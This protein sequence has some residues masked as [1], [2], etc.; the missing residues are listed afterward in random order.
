MGS[1]AQS[2]LASKARYLGGLPLCAPCPPAVSGQV[3]AAGRGGQG[4][5]HPTSLV[6]APMVRGHH[7]AP[8]AHCA[9]SWHICVL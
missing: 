9:C 2:L 5:G 4:W 1:E 7:R 3:V 6:V 8:R